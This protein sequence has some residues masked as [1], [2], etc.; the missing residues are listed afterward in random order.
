MADY[1]K[2][3]TTVTL[4]PVNSVDLEMELQYHELDNLYIARTLEAKLKIQFHKNF[5][6]RTI[7]QITNN[8]VFAANESSKELAIYP[9]FTYKPGAKTSVYVGANKLLNKEKDI[10]S[11]DVFADEDLTNYFLKVTYTFDLL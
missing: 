4:R 7:L 8:D 3:E 1:N 5:W 2:Y 9:M 11:E 10:G 6:I